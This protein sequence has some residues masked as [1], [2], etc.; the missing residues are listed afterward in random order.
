VT[1]VLGSLSVENTP[2]A[3]VQ[4][5]LTAAFGAGK[6]ELLAPGLLVAETHGWIG[7]TALVDGSRL[8]ELLTALDRRRHASPHAAAALAWKMYTYSLVLPVVVGW[9]S[10]RRVPLVRPADVLLRIQEEQ[11]PLCLGLSRSV[12]IAV[13]PGDPLAGSAR[14]DVVPVA[15]EAQLLAVLRAAVLDDHL[16]PLMARVQGS[17]R[18]GDRPL[19][20]SLASGVSH[21]VL[22]TAAV[23]PAP[24]TDHAVTLLDALGVRDLVDLVAGPSGGFTVQRN[25]CCL[26]FTL[27][28]QKVCSGCCIRPSARLP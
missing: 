12:R 13:L 1:A 28:L 25:T 10:A 16:T 14:L 27:P 20:G 8:P 21:A 18:L 15:G 2:L 7:A 26:A 6:P 24:V 4:A 3:P 19:L 5:A 11:P 17:V 22:R 23:L 9:A